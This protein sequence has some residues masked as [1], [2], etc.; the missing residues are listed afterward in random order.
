V[1]QLTAIVRHLEDDAVETT[2]GITFD[3]LVSEFGVRIPDIVQQL[4]EEAGP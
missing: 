2:L 3:Q 4:N 1:G